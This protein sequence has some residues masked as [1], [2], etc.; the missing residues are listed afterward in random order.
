MDNNNNNILYARILN[1]E[2]QKDSFA[3]I[4]EH[5]TCIGTVQYKQLVGGSYYS[6]PV[7]HFQVGVIGLD[8][9]IICYCKRSDGRSEEILKIETKEFR[10]QLVRAWADAL[11][12]KV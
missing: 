10:S 5:I 2:P 11:G 8:V 7:Y 6:A 1:G 4:P 12:K 9:P 3:F